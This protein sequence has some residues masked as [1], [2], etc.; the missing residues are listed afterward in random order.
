MAE[1]DSYS[2]LNIGEQLDRRQWHSTLE[3]GQRPDPAQVYSTLESRQPDNSLF[4][5]YKQSITVSPQPEIFN[6]SSETPANLESDNRIPFAGK[7]RG[8]RKRIP[9]ILVALGVAIIIAAAA[10]GGECRFGRDLFNQVHGI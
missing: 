2:D 3:I 9:W 5:T 4:D 10:I 6:A 7:D 8:P 1:R